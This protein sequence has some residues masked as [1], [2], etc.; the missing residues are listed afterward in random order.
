MANTNNDNEGGQPAASGGEGSI[1]PTS[2]ST[3]EPCPSIGPGWTVRSVPRSK[4]S[5]SGSR[6]ID[7]FFHSPC[8]RVFR[9]KRAVERFLGDQE[10]GRHRRVPPSREAA[11]TAALAPE[12]LGELGETAS[13]T[14]VT[15]EKKTARSTE[16]TATTAAKRNK[17]DGKNDKENATTIGITKTTGDEGTEKKRDAVE[18][19]TDKK[20]TSDE[21]GSADE[22][23][24]FGRERDEKEGGGEGASKRIA[25]TGNAGDDSERGN[26]AGISVEQTSSDIR[27]KREDD[28]ASDSPVSRRADTTITAPIFSSIDLPPTRRKGGDSI[29]TKLSPATTMREGRIS[30]MAVAGSG[31][32]ICHTEERGGDNEQG[33]GERSKGDNEGDAEICGANDNR[34]M[35]DVGSGKEG[36]DSGSDVALHDLDKRGGRNST[37]IPSLLDSPVKNIRLRVRTSSGEILD[38]ACDPVVGDTAAGDADSGDSDSTGGTTAAAHFRKRPDSHDGAAGKDDDLGGGEADREDKREA[39]GSRE[40]DD[41]ALSDREQDIG[42]SNTEADSMDGAAMDEDF[43]S[44]FE[45]DDDDPGVEDDSSYADSERAGGGSEDRGSE[46]EAMSNAVDES[47]DDNDDAAPPAPVRGDLVGAPAGEGDSRNRGNR[48]DKESHHLY[49]ATIRI[50]GGKFDGKTGRITEVQSYR[51]AFLDTLP[52]LGPVHADDIEIISSKENADPSGLPSIEFGREYVGSKVRVKEPHERS[53]AVGLV[54]KVIV[55][56]WYIT[57]NREITNAFQEHKFEVIRY[58]ASSSNKR[59]GEKVKVVE[60]VE[61]APSREEISVEKV[62]SAQD[63]QTGREKGR[64][65]EKAESQAFPRE[66]GR[67]ARG[68]DSNLGISEEGEGTGQA[69]RSCGTMGDSAARVAHGNKAGPPSTAAAAARAPPRAD[70]AGAMPPTH[71]DDRDLTGATIRITRG[72]FRGRTACIRERLRIRRLEIDAVPDHP[73]DFPDVEVLSYRDGS[74]AM[75]DEDCPDEVRGRAKSLQKLLKLLFSSKS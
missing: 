74:D 49:G 67:Q 42:K 53:G 5:G 54:T 41:V 15:A 26:T 34:S 16:S 35:G 51:H 11:A 10:S 44:D 18:N 59:S 71:D 70:R 32:R 38:V 2:R 66:V 28:V 33:K 29:A 39:E 61:R 7:R 12:N 58:A 75:A 63:Q 62:T 24:V 64:N 21:K 3:L 13:T 68:A 8:G 65:V 27:D 36:S 25:T 9:S 52:P 6:V 48:N 4:R 31:E 60:E 37:G 43:G 40:G 45:D 19:F 47:G 23:I 1:S 50:K 14:A 55:G 72:R 30:G 69:A 20:D 17:G 56:D 73:F 46:E 22:K 57:D